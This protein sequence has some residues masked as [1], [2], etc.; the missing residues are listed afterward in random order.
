MGESK[1]AKLPTEEKNDHIERIYKKVEE[2]MHK[3]DSGWGKNFWIHNTVVL[4]TRL[5]R[6]LQA[7]KG[8]N[9]VA[10]P[11]NGALSEALKWEYEGDD[12][13]RV[14]GEDGSCELLEEVVN[15]VC[16]YF[17][18]AETSRFKSSHTGT[19]FLALPLK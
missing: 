3:E 15:S 4:S 13:V 14:K 8:E 9:T 7:G 5:I 19:L 12:H 6:Q 1:W 16:Y 11:L 18:K 2:A 10:I 17:V